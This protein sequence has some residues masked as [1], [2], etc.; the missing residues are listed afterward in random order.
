MHVL[1][2]YLHAAKA[3]PDSD[4]LVVYPNRQEVH[5]IVK[6]IKEASNQGSALL[7]NFIT[8]QDI[9]EAIDPAVQEFFE[10]YKKRYAELDHETL[11]NR[12]MQTANTIKLL[13]KQC[14]AYLHELQANKSLSLEAVREHVLAVESCLTY[15]VQV[16]KER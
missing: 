10:A 6:Y 14:Y 3:N 5:P 9:L 7:C 8:N 12:S 15:A 4:F 16:Q 11:F 13:H 1:K 2:A